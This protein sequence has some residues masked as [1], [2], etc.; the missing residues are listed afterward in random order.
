MRTRT[1]GSNRW[2]PIAAG[3]VVVA[4][5]ITFGCGAQQTQPAAP[6]QAPAATAAPSSSASGQALPTPASLAACNQ[7]PN[8]AS[9]LD[10]L[11]E[12]RGWLDQAEHNKGGWREA[13]TAATDTAI[14][15]TQRGCAYADNH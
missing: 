12:A 10:K 5:A 4:L 7:Q 6:E 8:M 3:S 1:E 14:Q 2:M 13:A 9:A 11:R 15:E